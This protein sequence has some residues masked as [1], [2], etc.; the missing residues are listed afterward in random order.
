ME[1]LLALLLLLGFLALIPLSVLLNAFVVSHVWNLLMTPLFGLPEMTLKH[2]AALS[3]MV[4]AL[5]AYK[6]QKMA[7]EE[8]KEYL[9]GVLMKPLIVLAAAHAINYFM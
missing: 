9:V 1:V 6:H 3:L 7:K 5:S 4:G 2:A 8:Q